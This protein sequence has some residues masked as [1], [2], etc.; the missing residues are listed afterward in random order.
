MIS[1]LLLYDFGAEK[2]DF[3]KDD[4]IFSE[5]QPALCYYQIVSGE[6]KMNNFNEDGKEFIQGIFF[7]GQSFGEPPLFADV[8]YPAHAE[9]LSDAE[10][11]RLSKDNFMELLK[12]HPDQHL[13]ITKALAARLYYKSIMAAE[14]SSQDPEHR[15][16]RILD[17]LKKYV[18]NLTA[19]FS[20]QVDITR[21]QIADLTGL[22][23]ETVIRA[24]KS[25]EKKG[26]LKIKNRKLFR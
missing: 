10:V 15:I 2:L 1:E 16:L 23:V 5:G 14:L 18:H 17:Y 25:L 21:Q 26:E 9:T 8:K 6:V 12:A 19:P 7:K 4:R 11:L 20:F 22:R 3:V 13:E 24:T